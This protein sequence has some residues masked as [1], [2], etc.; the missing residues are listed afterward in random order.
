MIPFDVTETIDHIDNEDRVRYKLRPLAGDREHEVQMIIARAR[1][2]ESGKEDHDPDVIESRLNDTN[3]IFDMFVVGWESMDGRK[4]PPF[5]EDGQ[6]SKL[7][8]LNSKNHMVYDVILG[9]RSV[10]GLDE[11]EKK[12]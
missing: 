7:F 5:P 2:A 12:S 4:L 11:D 3:K 1:H 9:A 8:S 10:N 6:P